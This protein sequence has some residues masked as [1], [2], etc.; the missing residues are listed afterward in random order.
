MKIL[1]ATGIYPPDIGGPATYTKLLEKELPQ[2]DIEVSVC[3]FGEVRHL[4]RVV[5]HLSY[6]FKILKKGKQIDC[7]YA[8]DPVSVGLPAMLAAKVLKKRFIVKIVGD[9][10]WEQYMQTPRGREKM[11]SP[12]EFQT[13]RYGFLTEVRR[14]IQY[15]VARNASDI[16]VPS[17]YLKRIVS[18]WLVGVSGLSGRIDDTDKIHVVYN[19][20]KPPALSGFA[21]GKELIRGMMKFKGKMVITAGRL[22]P[23]KGLTALV[24][25]APRFIKHFPDSRLV[26]VGDGP[27]REALERRIALHNLGDRVVLTGT[28]ERDVLLR[29]IQ[30]A[31]V[32]VLNTLY[33]G[34]SHVLLEAASLGTPIVT[35]DVGGNPELFRHK[36]DALLVPYDDKKGLEKSV[37]TLLRDSVLAKKFSVRS[38]KNAHTFSRERMI[39]GLV[40]VLRK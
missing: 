36:K 30:A 39:N 22:V 9:Y 13:R 16:V 3:S 25:I 35:T 32:F 11:I 33:E 29:Y 40:A 18:Q 31:D 19:S 21:G 26:I 8:Q 10:A 38:Q 24:D 34:F 7:I 4:P 28:L 20:F 6:F 15:K 27:E 17:K 14:Y 2:Y 1:I 12:D 37:V 5:R 23:W